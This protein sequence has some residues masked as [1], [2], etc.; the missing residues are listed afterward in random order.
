MKAGL[1]FRQFTSAALGIV[2]MLLD[3]IVLDRVM[4]LLARRPSQ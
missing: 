2:H 1:L 3:C 4:K